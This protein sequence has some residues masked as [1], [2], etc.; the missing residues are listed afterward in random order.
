M[1][2][3][4]SATALLE[5]GDNGD[6]LAILS[7]D[8]LDR[9]GEI[10]SPQSWQLPLPDTIPFNTNHESGVES[11][12]GSATPFL[13]GDGRLM[14]RGKFASNSAAQHIRGL[15]R[16]GHL[17]TVSVEFVRTA[18]KNILVGGAFV[19][20]P[21]NPEARIISAKHFDTA[22]KS[23]LAGEPLLQAIHDASVHLG[24][25]CIAALDPDMD[26]DV[27]PGMDGTDGASDGANK[28]FE[29]K[30]LQLRLKAL[31]R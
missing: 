9:D 4:K 7:T 31:S 22:L 18:D 19:A 25:G 26:G 11:I 2:V 21:S 27:D 5:P 30:A 14:V 15:V 24:A 28:A 12:V 20:I 29:A 8:A 3:H 13:D 23:V 6:F 17:G 16:E 10:V 1:T